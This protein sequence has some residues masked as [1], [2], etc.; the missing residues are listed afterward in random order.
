[1]WII[2]QDET[3]LADYAAVYA[4]GSGIPDNRARKKI[5]AIRCLT[6]NYNIRKLGGCQDDWL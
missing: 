2:G 3:L 4:G 5:A 1:M 6:H